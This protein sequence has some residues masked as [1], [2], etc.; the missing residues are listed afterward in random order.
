MQSDELKGG[1]QEKAHCCRPF[2]ELRKRDD[3]F[4]ISGTRFGD[5]R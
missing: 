5:F 3:G 4:F 2:G 1:C